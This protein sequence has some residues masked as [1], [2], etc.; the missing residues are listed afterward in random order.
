[1]SVECLEET[2]GLRVEMLY[3]GMLSG[4]QGQHSH[5]H[6]FEHAAIISGCL[7]RVGHIGLRRSS[8]SP[9]GRQ[10]EMRQAV[11]PLAAVIPLV[12]FW[13]FLIF[14]YSDVVV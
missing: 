10:T 2:V 6:V 13:W 12:C 7:T 9:D 8:A 4:H 5:C 11:P 3:H 14:N 1:M